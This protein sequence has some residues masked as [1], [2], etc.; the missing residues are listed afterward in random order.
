MVRKTWFTH[1][2]VLFERQHNFGCSVP[3]C[4]YVFSHETSFRS[5]WLGSLNGACETEVA[6]LEVAIGVEKEVGGL[7][8]PMDDIGRVQ[9]LQCAERLV[10]EVLGVIVR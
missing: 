5:R 7:E 2:G 4:S 1:L 8:I 3:P 9:C 10:D 6:D